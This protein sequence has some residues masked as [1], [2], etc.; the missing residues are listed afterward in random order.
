MNARRLNVFVIRDHTNEEIEDRGVGRVVKIDP[1]ASTD[2]K[3]KKKYKT[4]KV[5]DRDF[6]GN[7]TGNGKYLIKRKRKTWKELG[8]YH[9]PAFRVRAGADRVGIEREKEAGQR[10]P[11]NTLLLLTNKSGTRS[12]GP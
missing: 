6:R 10:K 1:P 7:S 11:P 2:Q 9:R 5:P 4:S 12:A 3:V 8:E